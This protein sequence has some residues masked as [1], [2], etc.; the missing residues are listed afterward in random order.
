M[1]VYSIRSHSNWQLEKLYRASNPG[2]SFTLASITIVESFETDGPVLQQFSVWVAFRDLKMY[3]ASLPCVDLCLLF[4]GS[5]DVW[6]RKWAKT[7][8]VTGSFCQMKFQVFNP[9][10]MTVKLSFFFLA[11]PT[12]ALCW[13]IRQPSPS[14]FSFHFTHVKWRVGGLLSVTLTGQKT[15]CQDSSLTNQT[16][17]RKKPRRH[18][19]TFVSEE[20]RADSTKKLQNWCDGTRKQ[21]A[22]YSFRLW[23]H[24]QQLNDSYMEEHQ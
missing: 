5:E 2:F 15:V 22:T 17:A 11:S 6:K 3:N 23:G 18:K 9:H 24:F 20:R 10:S 1:I 7:C 8:S 21:S 14:S 19:E 12:H 4:G 13:H 16:P